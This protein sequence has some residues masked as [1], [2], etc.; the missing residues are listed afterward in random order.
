ML[1]NEVI[2]LADADGK[3]IYLEATVAGRPLYSKLGWAV[4]DLVTFDLTKW[5]GEGP[6]YN[7]I[8]MR[9]PKSKAEV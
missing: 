2:A 1:L 6:A 7:W 9:Q 4:I 3:R 8:M 5:G